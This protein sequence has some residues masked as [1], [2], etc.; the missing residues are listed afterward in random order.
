VRGV[1]LASPDLHGHWREVVDEAQRLVESGR[2][3]ELVAPLMGAPWYRLSAANVV[4][5]VRVL[6]RAYADDGAIASVAGPLLAFFGTHDVGAEAELE[7]IRRHA[8]AAASVETALLA[9]GDH[10]YTGVEAEAAELVA[11]WIER[12]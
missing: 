5:R 3:D 10:V 6:G 9:G 11:G 4:S 2:G 12:L 1:V 7:T 8:R